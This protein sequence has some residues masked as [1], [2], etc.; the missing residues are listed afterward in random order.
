MK[1][2]TNILETKM[3]AFMTSMITMQPEASDL[4]KLY[5]A[6][7]NSDST[8]T[9]LASSAA[10]T[11]SS[12]LTKQEVINALTIS[13]QIEKFF[14][15]VAM[16][17]ADYR[18]NIEGIIHG[19]DAYASPGIS[20]AIEGF[21]E[22]AVTMCQDILQNYKDAIDILDVYFDTEIS[23][24][25]GAVTVEEC[26]WYNFSKSDFTEGISLIENFKKLVNNEAATTG[27]YGSTVAKWRKIV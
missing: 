18:I 15:N 24:A 5:W 7:V 4:V 9:A 8:Y 12:Q 1:T 20:V 25:I 17:Q 3:K 14:T 21:G 19:N 2:A 10:A 11:F 27:D 16:T 6:E 13:E 22:R 26:P 23:A